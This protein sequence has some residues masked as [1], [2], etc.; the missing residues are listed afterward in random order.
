[1]NSGSKPSLKLCPKKYIPQ[2]ELD[3]PSKNDALEKYKKNTFLWQNS[4]TFQQQKDTK[5]TQNFG[6]DW[7]FG[8]V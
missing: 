4:I 8:D 3:R 6:E 1:M 7:S 2:N 5:N